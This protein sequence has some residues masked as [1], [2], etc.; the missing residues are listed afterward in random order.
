MSTDIVFS[1]ESYKKAGGIIEEATQFIKDE[2]DKLIDSVT[3]FE[4]LGTNDTVGKIANQLYRVFIEAFREIVHG[5]IDG[6]VD[7]SETL[8]Q[9]G[10]L[11]QN[12]LEAASSLAALIG[13]DY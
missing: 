4:A 3:D 2:I 6:L 13:K 7:Q 10:E 1:P 11:Y 12:T 8:R 5:L 9:V